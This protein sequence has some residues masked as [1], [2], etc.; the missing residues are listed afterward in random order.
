M[1]VQVQ[2]SGMEDPAILPAPV[3]AGKA[4]L[5]A[6]QLTPE[7][8]TLA[9]PAAVSLTTRAGFD[10]QI[11]NGEVFD[12]FRFEPVGLMIQAGGWVDSGVDATV[13]ANPNLGGRKAVAASVGV[14]RTYAV[15]IN[16]LDGDGRRDELDNCPGVANA[17]QLNTDGDAFGDACD[18]APSDPANPVPG[19]VG[20]TM[21]VSHNR[22]TGVT[23]LQWSA[24]PVATLYNT[25]RGAIG[26]G[27][28]AYTHTCLE[29][30]D[31]AGNG[32]TVSTD[33]ASPAVGLG[34]YY[35]ASG[36]SACGEGSTGNRSNG[37]PHP[38][39]SPCPTPPP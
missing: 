14:L 5:G 8:Q 36:E 17:N 26:P 12:L 7:G 2:L 18:C 30:G 4:L 1:A 3:P 24:I 28:F 27:S 22:G 10:G 23:T 38:S 31:T 29:S 20:A 16:D 35:L 37:T 32:A 33:G 39:P 21:T 34:F 19:L 15:F 11:T 6:V 9:S 25:Y 13:G